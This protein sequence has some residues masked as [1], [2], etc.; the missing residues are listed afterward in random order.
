MPENFA[1]V[2]KKL[3]RGGIPS[4]DDLIALHKLG[5]KKV[6]SLDEDS[7]LVIEDICK[8]LGFEHV[9]WGLTTGDDPKVYVLKTKIIPTL[10]LGGPTYIHCKHGKD[11]T[12]M[13]VAMFRIYTG[14]SLNDALEEAKQ[15]KMGVDLSQSTH[16][17]YFDAVKHYHSEFDQNDN[18]DIVG[19]SRELNLNPAM[20]FSAPNQHNSVMPR[21]TYSLPMDQESVHIP[22][23]EKTASGKIFCKCKFKHLF[24]PTTKWWSDKEDAI[25]NYI[26]KDGE[27]YSANINKIAKSF[28]ITSPVT[29]TL[30]KDIVLKHIFDVCKF[31]NGCH[32]IMNPE[33]LINIQEEDIEDVNNV[34]DLSGSI[35][36]ETIGTYTITNVGSGAGSC[37][38]IMDNMQNGLPGGSGVGAAGV[39]ITPYGNLN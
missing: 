19:L 6:V 10:T 11:R 32:I 9:I 34:G 1:K 4:Y 15:F 21:G 27:V 31:I 20:S 28:V 36:N 14:W 29:K 8:A 7:G 2:T 38:A 18:S 13:A 25:K 30:L 24:I 12:S 26:D 37:G 23:Y 35:N 5:I 22:M 17:S 39:T 16:D 3:Y 33:C